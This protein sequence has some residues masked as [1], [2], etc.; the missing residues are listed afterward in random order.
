MESRGDAKR[1]TMPQIAGT[2]ENNPVQ[3]QLVEILVWWPVSPA[4]LPAVRWRHLVASRD[5]AAAAGDV[6]TRNDPSNVH[7]MIINTN[8]SRSSDCRLTLCRVERHLIPI[9]PNATSTRTAYS[10]WMHL[11]PNSGSCPQPSPTQRRFHTPQTPRASLGLLS[12]CHH[13]VPPLLRIPH[14]SHLIYSENQSP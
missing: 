2:T 14:G 6:K 7:V 13:L 8:G 1:P 9:N 5:T 3:T 11:K 12:A 4:S 10:E